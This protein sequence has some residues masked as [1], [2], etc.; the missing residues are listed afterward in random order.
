MMHVETSQIPGWGAD[1]DKANRPAV[2]MEK[3]P[4]HGTGAHWD[5]PELQ[6]RTM[7]VFKSIE[8]PRMPPVFG[9]SV[10]PT[11]LSGRIK[12]YAYSF[13]EGRPARWL[14]ILLADRINV[15]EGLI[16]DLRKGH[17]PNIFAEMGWKAEWKYNREGFIKKALVVSGILAGGYLFMK[18]RRSRLSA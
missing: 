1:L 4:E 9:T 8:H 18:S 14:P 13:G 5:I 17:I 12:E 3:T 7:K 15:V 10:P 2:P 11:G 6:P 16:D